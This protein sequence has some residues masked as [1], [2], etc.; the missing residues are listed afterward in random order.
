[1]KC[2]I[3]PARLRR[4]GVAGINQRNGVYIA[5]HNERKRYPL[6]D[7]KLLTK[8]LA[9]SAGVAVPELYAVIKTHRDI[10]DLDRLL[11]D[12]D[13]FVIKPVHGSGGS[14]I[15]LFDGKD[16]HGAY[17]LANGR[18]M[19][20]GELGHYV[21]NIL[22]GAYSLGGRPDTAMIEQRV[23]FSPV[24]E[25]LSYRGVPDT[26]LIV[27]RGCPA[28]A[29]IRLPTRQSNGRANLHQGA[30][31][32]GIDL[33]T[34]VTLSAVWLNQRIDEHPDTGAAI[35][36]NAIP[37]WHTQVELA[38]RCYDLTG[39]G[40]LGVDL[41]LDRKYGPLLLELNARPGLAIQIANQEGLQ[42][43]FRAIDRWLATQ[44][45]LPPA[46][47]RATWFLEKGLGR[48][49]DEVRRMGR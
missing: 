10:R 17:R 42:W 44:D 47:A 24:F 4:L 8:A 37:D 48:W 43:R 26:R 2:W 14:G 13:S 1:M 39:L 29:M 19:A 35:A 22:A 31:G 20:S 21:S 32:A 7:N 30:I 25:H 41:V 18:L 23:E 11:R 5:E 9:S 33:E 34:G 27:Y 3:S 28:M 45:G 38:T 6:V 16:D 36:D 49:L 12:R 46:S 15:L 40:Y